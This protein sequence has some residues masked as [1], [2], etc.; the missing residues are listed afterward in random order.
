MIT[1][2][3]R[4][5]QAG[6]E[7]ARGETEAQGGFTSTHLRGRTSHSHVN[8]RRQNAPRKA[9]KVSRLSEVRVTE[10]RSAEDKLQMTER[11]WNQTS[12][13]SPAH[14]RYTDTLPGKVGTFVCTIIRCDSSPG[15]AAEDLCR[16]AD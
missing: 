16:S 15:G 9:A 13:G 3:R 2:R 4:R 1:A 8:L 11:H 5:G 7:G 10:P 6:R 14:L 12:L